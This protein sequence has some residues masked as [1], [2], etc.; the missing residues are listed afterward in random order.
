LDGET[1]EGGG[2]VAAGAF[3]EVVEVDA[4]RDGGVGGGEVDGTGAVSGR[5]LVM[6]RAEGG[7]WGLT[8]YAPSI[9]PTSTNAGC[10][11]RYKLDSTL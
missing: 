5:L 10:S 2:G 3:G 7:I 11:H 1:V 9:Q 4:G 8:G 6:V